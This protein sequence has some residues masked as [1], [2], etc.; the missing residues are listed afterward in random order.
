VAIVTGG[1][2][3]IGLA[4]SRG[5]AEAGA[6]VVIANRDAI[7]GERAAAGLR[8]RGLRA[9]AVAADVTQRPSVQAMVDAVLR[10]FRRVDILVNNA[11][12]HVRKET[13]RLTDAEWE[14]L[15]GVNVTGT[16]LCSQIVGRHMIRRRRGAIVNLATMGAAIALPRGTAYC[17][18]K[19]AVAHFTSALA[20]EWGR[21]GVRVNA[22]APGSVRTAM[23]EEVWQDPARRRFNTQQA[24]L[25]RWGRPEDVAAAVRYLASD[26]A[27]YVTGHVLYV[28]GGRTKW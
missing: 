24:P 1:S 18:A 3:G 27:S 20:C 26:E 7:R 19:A 14:R 5:L 8:G 4:I 6:Q 15:I 10:R 21:F 11:G 16:F 17:A 2:Q 23:S 12:V 22:V 25:G 9:V 13:E 28:D